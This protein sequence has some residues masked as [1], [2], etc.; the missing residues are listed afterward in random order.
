MIL[1]ISHQPGYE[2]EVV[3][4]MRIDFISL[5]CIEIDANQYTRWQKYFILPS[6]FFDVLVQAKKN[7]KK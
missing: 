6:F 7:Y 1:I 5:L 3:V 2:Q 4:Q